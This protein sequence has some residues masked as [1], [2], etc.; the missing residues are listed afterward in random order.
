LII[1]PLSGRIM[2]IKNPPVVTIALILVNCIVF[3]AFRASDLKTADK[4]EDYYLRSGLALIEVKAHEQHRDFGVV[5]GLTTAA[6]S[7]RPYRL[8]ELYPR[9]A[10]MRQDGKFMTSLEKRLIITPGMEVYPQWREKRS[11]YESILSAT[12]AMGHGFRPAHWRL[13][14]MFT[15]MFIQKGLFYLVGNMLFLWLAGCVV[16]LAWGRLAMLAIYLAGGLFSAAIFGLIFLSSSEPLVGA[17]GA[18]AALMGAY[19]ILYGRKE[20]KVFYPLGVFFNH[21]LVPGVAILVLWL[22]NEF[23]QLLLDRAGIVACMAHIGGFSGGALLGYLCKR[24]LGEDAGGRPKPGKDEDSVPA[25]MD[26]A[27]EKAETLDVQGARLAF[28]Q[29]LQKDPDNRPALTRMFHLDKLQPDSVEFHDSSRK[30]IANLAGYK[31]AHREALAIY[32]EYLEKAGSPKLPRNMIFSLIPYFAST[33]HLEEAEE[34]VGTLL[35]KS[36][37]LPKIPESLLYLARACL[38]D[39]L[40]EKARSYFQVICLSY[41]GSKECASARRILED[42]ES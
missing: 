40:N 35:R 17:S 31:Q 4:A 9:M 38:K 22:L 24:R 34:I 36:P 27:L 12:T 20:I 42:L 39:G 2:G 6:V 18:I 28:Q 16:E 29:V 23:F 3:F 33:G 5:V 32:R 11:R 15:Y 7:G 1:V 14:S 41:P 19:A 13:D 25:L 10:A 26:S 37:D 21:T 30:L 8:S